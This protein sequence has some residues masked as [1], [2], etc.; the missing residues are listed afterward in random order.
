M[1]EEDGTWLWFYN[2]GLVEASETKSSWRDRMIKLADDICRMLVNKP[3][4]IFLS[5]VG[6][7]RSDK[8]D[9]SLKKRAQYF[10][11]T[12]AA[13]RQHW[14][15]TANSR[16]ELMHNM[17]VDRGWDEEYKIDIAAHY[18]SITHRKHEAAVS[19]V[20]GISSGLKALM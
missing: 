10:A 4:G 18:V 16:S 17:A 9:K 8:L 1:S 12:K 13:M 11:T 14:A 7:I 19:L 5:E 3:A 2:V 15:D 20:P 6:N